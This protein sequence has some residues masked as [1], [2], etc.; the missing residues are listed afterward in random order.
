M[1]ANDCVF[2]DVLRMTTFHAMLVFYKE[3]EIEKMI[4]SI[5]VSER[6]LFYDQVI[7]DSSHGKKNKKASLLIQI[8]LP[9]CNPLQLPSNRRSC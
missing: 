1:P 6:L 4:E 9:T 8:G 3:I 5:G 7:S 2:K